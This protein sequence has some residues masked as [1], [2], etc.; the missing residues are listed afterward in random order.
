MPTLNWAGKD[1][2]LEGFGQ[3]FDSMTYHLDAGLMIEC[4]RERLREIRGE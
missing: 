2:V 3:G 4:F 1:K